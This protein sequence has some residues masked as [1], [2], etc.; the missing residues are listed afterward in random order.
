MV[1]LYYFWQYGEVKGEGLR[2]RD[3]HSLPLRH[4]VLQGRFINPLR[5]VLDVGLGVMPHQVCCGED[6]HPLSALVG[7]ECVAVSQSVGGQA[8]CFLLERLPDVV[9]LS[10]LKPGELLGEL[11][12]DWLHCP[13][14]LSLCVHALR[15][16]S[17]DRLGQ[18]YETALKQAQ[19]SH[20]LSLPSLDVQGESTPAGFHR[21]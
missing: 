7:A 17:S 4:S 10:V 21:A 16:L 2:L 3:Q 5:V 11:I 8:L 18:L 6:V 1:H 13:D 14:D 12:P 19:I 9:A 15:D 20:A